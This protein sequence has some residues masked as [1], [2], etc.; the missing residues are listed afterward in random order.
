MIYL[1][2]YKK[3]I[4]YYNMSKRINVPSL[5]SGIHWGLMRNF[6]HLINKWFENTEIDDLNLIHKAIIL[7]IKYDPDDRYSNS[8][9][10][11][12]T[13]WVANIIDSGDDSGIK[14]YH[15][16]NFIDVIELFKT[17]GYK[18]IDEDLIEK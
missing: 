18:F 17:K 1:K 7:G 9:G 6:E 12:G 15:F 14:N 4:I 13:C 3:I 11:F 5:G 2:E 8:D 10:Y 16:R